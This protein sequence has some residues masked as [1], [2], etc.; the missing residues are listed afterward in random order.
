MNADQIHFII[1]FAIADG[2]F[3]DFSAALKLMTER[4]AKEPGALAYEWF[5]SDDQRRCRLMETYAD[6]NAMKE[7]LSGTVVQELVPKLLALAKI[8]RF[9]VYGAPDAQSA[10]AL[11]SFG[12]EIFRCWSGLPR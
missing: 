2:K 8:S 10:V 3:D 9:E 11:K 1:D 12:A 7:H 6:V 5:L 4:T